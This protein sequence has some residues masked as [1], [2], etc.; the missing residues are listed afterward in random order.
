MADVTRISGRRMR[1]S[2]PLA[3]RRQ[4]Y[5]VREEAPHHEQTDGSRSEVMVVHEYRRG[6]DDSTYTFTPR[7][8]VAEPVD[9]VELLGRCDDMD[10]TRSLTS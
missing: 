1:R 9:V 10:T 4:R 8:R 6:F 7:L 5:G 2:L 3:R